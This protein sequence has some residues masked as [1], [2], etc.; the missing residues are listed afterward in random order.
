MTEL[1]VSLI[2]SWLADVDALAGIAGDLERAGM[3]FMTYGG[4]VLAAAEGRYDL[5]PATYAAPFRDHFVVFSYLAA[6]TTRL[7]FRS[8][9]LIL[10]LYPTALVAKQS[11]ELALVSGDRFELGVGI[12]WNE[13][14][15]R[16]L[17][18]DA[19]VRGARLEEQLAVLNRF[20]REPLVTFSGRF[21]EI[22]ELGLGRLPRR[23]V[24]IWVG[25]GETDALL[26]RVARHANG[27]MPTGTPTA[28]RVDRLQELAREAGRSAPLGV[29][30]RVEPR[31][32]DL[33][34]VLD[35]AQ[36]LVEVG[37]TSLIISTPADRSP[38]DGL[39]AVLATHDY[40]REHLPS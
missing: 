5:H 36:A 27:W 22:D 14:E 8:G 32:D 7:R 19:K 38:R 20:W 18:Q 31:A 33:P 4:H 9:I 2:H 25:C 17:G 26:G 35:E 1:G 16:A 28:E 11:A 15:Y 12:S 29:S 37:A 23:P 39:A 24:P 10:P 30:L 40:L 6:K 34:R 13:P 3:D 21:H